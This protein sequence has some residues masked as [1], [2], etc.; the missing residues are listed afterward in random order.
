[1]RTRPGLALL[2]LLIVA[3]CGSPAPPT[4]PLPDN[5]Q[6]F[7]SYVRDHYSDTS[8]YTDVDLLR[9]GHQICDQIGDRGYD[10]KF[11]E[12]VTASGAFGANIGPIVV[13]AVEFNLCPGKRY[14]TAPVTR[15]YSTAP[16][17]VAGIGAAPAG[18]P[19]SMGDG[20]WEVGVDVQP[21]KYKTAGGS[22]CYWA[23]LR[24]NDGGS[25]DIINNN[26]GAGPQTVT[27][28]KGEYFKS[29]RCGAWSKA[30]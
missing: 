19:T 21:G 23:R 6:R 24:K 3:G 20:T 29:Q 30:G 17:P 27:V 13:D 7:V 12:K 9:V 1:M 26:V 10:R 5:E 14:W 22:S 8:R 16:A 2:A 28:N 4:N 18:P 11:A 25:N 15:T